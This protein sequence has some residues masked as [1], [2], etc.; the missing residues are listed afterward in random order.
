[1]FILNTFLLLLLYSAEFKADSILKCSCS[2]TEANGCIQGVCE[3][4]NVDG[5]IFCYSENDLKSCVST[6]APSLSE[7]LSI[8]SEIKGLF[9]Y[10]ITDNYVKKLVLYSY[11]IILLY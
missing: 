8:T 3:F 1:M 11:C 7:Y 10:I 4:Q 5:D 6:D 2:D 9:F